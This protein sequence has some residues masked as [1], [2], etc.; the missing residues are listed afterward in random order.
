MQSTRLNK[1]REV[2]PSVSEPWDV[3]QRSYNN[4]TPP[5]SHR[6]SFGV[7]DG[8]EVDIESM[9]DDDWSAW[10]AARAAKREANTH[11]QQ[12]TSLG[13]PRKIA[14]TQEELNLYLVQNNR[15]AIGD[16]VTFNNYPADGQM[17]TLHTVT[18]LLSV[19]RR[20]DD[21]LWNYWEDVPKPYLMLSLSP[22]TRAATAVNPWPASA[23]WDNLHYKRHLTANEHTRLIKDNVQL[24]DYIEQA[25]TSFK[26]GRLKIE[27]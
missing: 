20:I 19:E 23:R 13:S 10:N 3:Y 16:F 26:T 7:I 11:L 12:N 2:I 5:V 4:Y 6:H 9:N 15:W 18:L 22:A 25:R 21:V 14:K 24:S 8:T 17:V 1:K 27:G